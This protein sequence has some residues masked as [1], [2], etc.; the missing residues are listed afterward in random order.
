[1]SNES[2]SGW[3]AAFFVLGMAFM[4]VV[5]ALT[6]PAFL[7]T[8][9]RAE[10]VK[11]QSPLVATG[12]GPAPAA[13]VAEQSPALPDVEPENAPATVPTP[14]V[15]TVEAE[16]PLVAEAPAPRREEDPVRINRPAAGN[17]VPAVVAVRRGGQRIQGRAVLIGN[18][19][20]EKVIAMDP[21]C[22]KLAGPAPTTRLYRVDENGGLADVVVALASEPGNV[23]W[24]SA[25]TP[26]MID[27]RNCFF[28]PYVS[29][30]EVGQPIVIKNSDPVLHNAHI[31]PRARGNRERNVAL[32]PGGKPTEVTFREPEDFITIKCDVH[33]W[34]FAYV[35]VFPHPYA[36]VTD[37]SGAFAMQVPPGEYTLIA[38]HRKAGSITNTV[39]VTR[40]EFPEIEFRFQAPAEI[41]KR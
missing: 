22:G 3:L 35:S 41:A 23:H 26:V 17:L 32:L 19:P 14:S 24:E 7:F 15:S 34:M 30:A 2:R 27:N 1:M 12:K 36:R 28:E 21:A 29:V 18:P 13:V 16:P 10:I 9:E 33:P 8:N 11:V 20:P 40:D 31:I 4:L 37:L 38:T 5:I 25:Q 6:K 39:R